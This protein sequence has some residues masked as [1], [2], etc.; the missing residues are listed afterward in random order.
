MTNPVAA[1][2]SGVRR[3]LAACYL[4]DVSAVSAF[5]RLRSLVS[6]AATAARFFRG[7]VWNGL[8]V[9]AVRGLAMAGLVVV[10]RVCGPE[11][12]GLVSGP[13]QAGGL[14]GTAIGYGTATASTKTVSEIVRT[15]TPTTATDGRSPEVEQSVR[16]CHEIGV[17]T[18]VGLTVA[19]L[20][21]AVAAFAAG[22]SGIA[23][24]IAFSGPIAG[25][26]VLQLTQLGL[27]A[28]LDRF[29]SQAGF[30]FVGSVIGVAVLLAICPSRSAP[31]L[32][33]G[34]VALLLVQSIALARG[35]GQTLRPFAG[36][37]AIPPDASFRQT[38]RPATQVATVGVVA[39]LAGLLVLWVTASQTEFGLFMAAN[40]S[41]VLLMFVPA[42][43]ATVLYPILVERRPAAIPV[44]FAAVVAAAAVPVMLAWSLRSTIVTVYG[45]EYVGLTEP[46]SWTLATVLLAAVLRPTYLALAARE[47]LAKTPWLA[48][49][50]GLVLVT[51][52]WHWRA[53]GASGLAAARFASFATH[54]I[55]AVALL[56][57]TPAM[58]ATSQGRPKTQL[59]VAA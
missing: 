8:A 22:W 32:L 36:R 40:Q 55:A 48:A 34:V 54:A 44:G 29:R 46:L 7:A 33:A 42:T 35:L 47:S 51:L 3:G 17:Q 58:P 12:F 28:S 43:L 38:A 56:V 20:V 45:S 59:E 18:G 39:Q 14:V 25:L 1:R 27:Y 16:R 5:V 26:T 23:V 52:A 4:A 2:R 41:F 53:D 50:S 37:S 10:A 24:P 49:A 9:L 21:L 15:S 19:G 13:N 6:S 31:W 57:A 11:L 30:G